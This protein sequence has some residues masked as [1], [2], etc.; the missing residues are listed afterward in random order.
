MSD[1]PATR[2]D[3]DDVLNVLKS[4]VQQTSEQFSEV[5][6][7]FD[8]MDDRFEILTFNID[9]RFNK[10]ELEIV[11]LKKTLDHF[12]TT[13]DKFVG[14]IDNYETEQAARDS[15]FEKLLEWARKVSKKTGI[16]L[17]NL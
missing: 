7:R 12:M 17:E 6:D 8:K 9:T 5:N 2:K 14:R 16:P 13:L 3:I 4:F 10:I 11:D 1:K 15:Q